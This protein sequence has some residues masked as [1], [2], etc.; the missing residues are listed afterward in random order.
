M[1]LRHFEKYR[2]KLDFRREFDKKIIR[3]GYYVVVIA[4][5]FLESQFFSN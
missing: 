2:R 3:R 4:S 5:L 1:R